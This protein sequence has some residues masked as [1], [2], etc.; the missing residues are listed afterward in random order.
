E[1][2]AEAFARHGF[3]RDVDFD[4]SFITK[5]AVR[6]T[7]RGVPA[8]R[9]VRDYERRFWPLRTAEQDARAYSLELQE[10][11]EA[12]GKGRVRLAPFEPEVR[13]LRILRGDLEAAANRLRQELTGARNE[14]AAM[15]RSLFWRARMAMV[16]LR[17]M[18]GGS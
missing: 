3:H 18:L 5:W 9:V 2:W 13:D 16:R 12:L 4:A 8:H 10:R 17:R 14:I 11:L 7:R 1:D 6:F 15:E